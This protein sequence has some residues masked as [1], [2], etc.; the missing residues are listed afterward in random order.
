ML[1]TQEKGRH[2]MADLAPTHHL[3]HPDHPP[4]AVARAPLS[5]G[6]LPP[7]IVRL[8][9][10]LARIEQRRQARLRELRAREAS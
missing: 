8:L 10:I 4:S 6:D 2:R 3:A 5:D 7:D 9:D 1:D